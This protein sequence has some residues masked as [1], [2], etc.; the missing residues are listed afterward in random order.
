MASHGQAK[1]MSGPAAGRR[2]AGDIDVFLRQDLK[3]AIAQFVAAHATGH[4]HVH[5][6]TADACGTAGKIRWRAAETGAIR[7][8]VP[9]N[10]AE[11]GD[12]VF[13]FH[14]SASDSSFHKSTIVR[15]L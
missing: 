7:K 9:E 3:G 5:G 10:F 12:Y 2:H 4:K 15:R 1:P 8:N 13:G 11:T 14:L 6:M